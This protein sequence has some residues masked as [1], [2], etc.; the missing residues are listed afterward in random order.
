[1]SPILQTILL[2][3]AALIAGAINSVAGGGSFI[4]FPMLVATGVPEINA[5]MTNTIALWPGS[6][7][8]VGAYRKELN[9]QRHV[10]LPFVTISFIGGLLGAYLLDKTDK[11]TFNYLLP[12]LML[13]AT[14]VF[15]FSGRITRWLRSRQKANG[16]STENNK[17]SL[18]SIAG[19]GLLQFGVATYGG[20]FGGGIGIM[21]LAVL[22]LLGMEDIHAM[23]ALKTLLATC[24]NGVAVV[25]FAT[26]GK[27]YWPQGLLMVAGAIVGGY[28]GAVF[29]KKV[30]PQYVRMGVIAIGVLLTAYF[31][32]RPH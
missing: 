12:F 25:Y 19:T 23:N 15:A 21:M 3:F 7:A 5:N 26:T 20:F 4:S 22:G 27:V 9:A 32:L 10:L 16:M 6:A 28:Y 11:T 30:N 17:T 31:F 29:A 1:M 18:W 8:S 24:I 14:T 2:F 13:F